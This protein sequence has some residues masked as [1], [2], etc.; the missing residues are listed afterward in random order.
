MTL[1]RAFS[2]ILSADQKVVKYTD[3]ACDAQEI[4]NS[5]DSTMSINEFLFAL[6]IDNINLV[7]VLQYMK[8]SN[9]IHKVDVFLIPIQ[10]LFNSPSFVGGN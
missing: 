4:K 10:H 5:P 2:Q 1:T 7:K 9:I 6:N 3:P 8:E